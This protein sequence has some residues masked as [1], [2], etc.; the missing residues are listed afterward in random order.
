MKILTYTSAL[1]LLTIACNVGNPQTASTTVDQS[2]KP[3][4]FIDQPLKKLGPALLSF[5][6]SNST[7]FLHKTSKGSVIM[8]PKDAFVNEDG[9]LVQGNVT[10]DFKEIF[11]A[12]EIIL[13]GIPMNVKNN[14]VVTPFISD[15]MFSIVAGCN[16]RNVKLAEGK[17]ISVSTPSHKAETDFDY[18]YFNEVA[19]EWEKTGDR[20]ATLSAEE[21]IAQATLVNPELA[22]DLKVTELQSADPVSETELLAEITETKPLEPEKHDP[23]AFVFN[24]AADYN[25]Y[26]ELAGYKHVLWKPETELN[27]KEQRNLG[28]EM[29]ASGANV[30][31]NCLSEDDQVYEISYG[32]KRIKARPVYIGSDKEKAAAK[33]KDRLKT[34]NA[35][36]R[37]IA[38]TAANAKKSYEQYQKTYSMFQVNQMGIYN[39]DRFYS[40]KGNKNNYKFK[41][42]DKSADQYVFAVLSGNQGVI[43]LSA[44]YKVGDV[45]NLPSAEIIGFV[46]TSPNGEVFSAAHDGQSANQKNEVQ[47]TR[48][49]KS[50]E[51]PDDLQNILKNL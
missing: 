4:S 34:Y 6:F 33:Y 45:Y 10:I 2:V 38:E 9:S 46:H 21:V 39:C 44:A 23:K 19:G 8:V 1:L 30:A 24:I 48:R 22:A 43:A 15:G 32:K 26:P 31:L 16:G 36:M 41:A 13:S 5:V 25:D 7:G 20:N 11:T 28:L 12:S 51:S 17:S 47:L 18:W 29:Q 27:E 42:G 3:F 37:K 40:Y 49:L 14:G 50:L 35:E